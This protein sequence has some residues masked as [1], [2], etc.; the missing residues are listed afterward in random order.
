MLGSPILRL[1]SLRSLINRNWPGGHRRKRR[2]F[3]PSVAVEPFELRI[4]LSAPSVE[5]PEVSGTSEGTNELPGADPGST[6]SAGNQSFTFNLNLDLDGNGVLDDQYD[7]DADE[8]ILAINDDDDLMLAELTIST[9]ADLENLA[10]IL[11]TDGL[12][13]WTDSLKTQ[14]ISDQFPLQLPGGSTSTVEVYIEGLELGTHDFAPQIADLA[15]GFPNLLENA[16]WWTAIKVDQRQQAEW[17]KK[18][19]ADEKPHK[20]TIYYNAFGVAGLFDRLVDRAESI[21]IVENTPGSAMYVFR[22]DT[23]FVWDV[24]TTPETTVTHET[25]HALDAEE[26]WYL[27]GLFPNAH[28][29]EALTYTNESLLNALRSLAYFETQLKEGQISGENI[30]RKWRNT[31]VQ[32]NNVFNM[33][34]RISSNNIRNVNRTDIYDVERKLGLHVQMQAVLG[35]YQAI[36]NGREIA[37]MLSLD[38]PV[39]LDVAFQ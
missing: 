5:D 38:D 26:G 19:R 20:G 25:V 29:A 18:L 12:R 39:S 14:E 3:Q 9:D 13:F 28:R 11:A 33:P 2:T 37:Y 30:E 16:P 17:I 15:A 32:F 6:G 4:L 10:L 1:D 21:S 27:K 22:I 35:Q 31:L 24:T 23:V 34:I 7:S 36:V 8:V